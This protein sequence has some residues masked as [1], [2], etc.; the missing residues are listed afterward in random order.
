MAQDETEP[1]AERRLA[2]ILA[3][4]VAGYSRLMG[5]DEEGTLRALKGHRKALVDPSIAAHHGRIVKTTGDGMLVEFASVIDAARCAVEIQREM[6]ARNKD[7][8]SEKRIEFRMGINIGDIIVDGSDIFGDGVNV[9]ARLEGIAEPG[10][11]TI[12][13]L[14]YDQI[15]GKLPLSFRNLGLQKLKNIAKLVEVFAIDQTNKA[16]DA[17]E[18]DQTDATQIIKYCRAPD[19]VR[20][21]YAISGSGPF[22][23]KSGNWMNH[24]EYDWESPIWRHLFRGLSREHTLVRYDAR[25]MACPTG[26]STGFRLTPGW[27]ISRRSSM[28]SAPS[29]FRFSEFPKAAPWRLSMQ[30]GTRSECRTLFCMARS[31]SAERSALRL[32]KKCARRWQL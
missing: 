25:G 3:S 5:L 9:A 6:I 31:R 17:L 32:R 18:P 1:R 16:V 30:C 28:R 12:S 15:D 27:P 24:L 22:L 13:R 2:A 14:V 19:G 8:P 29:V 23:V 4:D 21:A 7:I 20:L 10:G 26:T 11:I